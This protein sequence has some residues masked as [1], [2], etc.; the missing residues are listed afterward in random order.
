MDFER[1]KHLCHPLYK[2]DY[3]LFKHFSRFFL[4][5]L[6]LRFTVASAVA[7]VVRS[8]R[9]VHAFLNDAPHHVINVIALKK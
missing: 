1:K 8:P 4:V 9:N 6:F 3:T 2:S 7:T 5:W